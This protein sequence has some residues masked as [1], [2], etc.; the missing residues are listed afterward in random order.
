MCLVCKLRVWQKTV[1]NELESIALRVQ[2]VAR[3]A[4]CIAI[5]LVLITGC[6]RSDEEDEPRQAVVV[7]TA[8]D[9][10]QPLVILSID[11][12]NQIANRL[13]QVWAAQTTGEVKVVDGSSEMLFNQSAGSL[14]ACDIILYPNVLVGELI[15]QDAIQPI[16]A[17][18]LRAAGADRNSLLRHDR[19]TVV[20]NGT[21]LFGASLGSPMWMMLYRQDVFE[22]HNLTV[23]RTWSEFRTVLEKL[24][25][26]GVQ[27]TDATPNA[28]PTQVCIPQDPESLVE[29]F[30][31]RAA[32]SILRQGRLSTYFEFDSMKALINTPPFVDAL[33]Q[34]VA[35]RKLLADDLKS[36]EECYSRL[37]QGR[38]AIAFAWP[39]SQATVDNG[40]QVLSIAVAP[41]PTSDRSYE[42]RKQKWEPI[43][44]NARKV[45]VLTPV[46]GRVASISMSTRKLRTAQRW[47]SWLTTAEANREFSNQFPDTLLVQYRQLEQPYLWVNEQLPREAAEQMADTLRV[48]HDEANTMVSLNLPGRSKYVAILSD[49]LVSALNGQATA[50]V[51]LDSAA[52][53]WDALTE[54]LGKEK[55]RKIFQGGI[56]VKQ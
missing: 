42:Y 28:L 19:T 11:D 44:E 46:A 3:A 25:E 49:A 33:E 20:Q 30:L 14:P 29:Y 56:G 17:D 36:P 37:I 8:N 32:G 4:T 6:Q 52:Q 2:G 45:T 31:T 34:I 41:L 26:D 12:P 38:A 24:Q 22:A 5:A 21:Q 48:Y 13:G 15:A 27:E 43:D 39:S 23:P 55:Q 16:D 47:I 10:P 18:Q 7:P 40:G 35:E 9:K 53:Q 50:Q 54:K 1:P 51:A